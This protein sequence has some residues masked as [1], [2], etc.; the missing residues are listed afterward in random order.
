MGAGIQWR[1]L[2]AGRA[3]MLGRADAMNLT[4]WREGAE[5][6]EDVVIALM[7][8]IF[9]SPFPIFTPSFPRKRESRGLGTAFTLHMFP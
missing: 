1:G 5:G 7:S 4:Q 8:P 2:G 3:L 9:A 6:R